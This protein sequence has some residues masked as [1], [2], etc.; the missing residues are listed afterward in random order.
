MKFSAAEKSV[1]LAFADR[2]FLWRRITAGI[3]YK[4]HTHPVPLAF[5]EWVPLAL[6]LWLIMVN[7]TVRPG[8]FGVRT[9]GSSGV[10]LAAD[11]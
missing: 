5:T 4:S 1:P 3:L 11:D 2:G 10:G 7:T 6:D 9:A 8:S